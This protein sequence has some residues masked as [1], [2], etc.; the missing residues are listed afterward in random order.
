MMTGV[1]SRLL[2]HY[3]TLQEEV[4]SADTVGGYKKS[5]VDIARFWAAIEPLHGGLRGREILMGD[6]PTSTITHRIMIRYRSGISA[7][8]RM[9]YKERYF[10]IRS[11]I[12]EHEKNRILIILA[13]EGV[14]L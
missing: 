10:N 7:G 8:Q 13:E 6:Q 1:L 2:R 5:W 11:I 3:V 14:A 12:N 9:M 4:R